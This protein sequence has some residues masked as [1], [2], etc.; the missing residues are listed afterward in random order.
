MWTEHTRQKWL[1]YM[2][3]ETHKPRRRTIRKMKLPRFYSTV[4]LNMDLTPLQIQFEKKPAFIAK[5]PATFEGHKGFIYVVRA[6]TL[7]LPPPTPP[8]QER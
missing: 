8:G 4:F 7:Q 6:C 2:A 1:E 3:G 5:Y